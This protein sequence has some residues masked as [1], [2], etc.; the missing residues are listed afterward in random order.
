MRFSE[1]NEVIFFG[2]INAFCS[3]F[4]PKRFLKKIKARQIAAKQ[5]LET[6]CY[7][8]EYGI[9][10]WLIKDIL[11]GLSVG[12]ASM[13]A[14]ILIGIGWNMNINMPDA[15]VL[16]IIFLTCTPALEIVDWTVFDQKRY[17]RFFRE[18]NYYCP[19][20]HKSVSP[21]S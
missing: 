11:Y 12:Y 8:V 3:I 5:Q 17:L 1:L 10:A 18:F 19:L 14:S 21:T 16:L 20:N 15:F 13:L 6:I 9:N 4:L 7:D 2:L